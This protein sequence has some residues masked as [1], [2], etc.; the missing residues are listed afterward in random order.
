MEER[1]GEREKDEGRRIER[2]EREREEE[3]ERERGIG[4]EGERIIE[5]KADGE[6]KNE[7]F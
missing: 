6:R 2:I 3:R 1:K 7:N 5:R 4:G